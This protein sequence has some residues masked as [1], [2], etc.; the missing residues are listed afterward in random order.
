[1]KIFKD[2]PWESGIKGGRIKLSD[3][4]PSC[5]VTFRSVLKGDGSGNLNLSKMPKA[6]DKCKEIMKLKMES[7][8]YPDRG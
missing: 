7:S 6:C 4:C 1:M 2:K 3:L 5:Q 8:K